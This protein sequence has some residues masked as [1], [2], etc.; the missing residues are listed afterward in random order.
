MTVMSK[1]RLTP[2]HLTPDRPGPTATRTVGRTATWTVRRPSG[3]TGT[4]HHQRR[5][6]GPEHTLRDRTHKPKIPTD[7]H[8][9]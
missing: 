4:Q 8:L 7:H 3:R 9:L 1:I 6:H 5:E 2:D